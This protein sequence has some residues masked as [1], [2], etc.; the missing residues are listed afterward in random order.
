MGAIVVRITVHIGPPT[1]E[2][3]LQSG[4]WFELGASG[5]TCPILRLLCALHQTYRPS[6]TAGD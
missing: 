1:C 2:V 5:E 4:L 6:L 3:F